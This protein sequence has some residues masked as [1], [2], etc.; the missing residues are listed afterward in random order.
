MFSFT[1]TADEWNVIAERLQRGNLLF[2]TGTTQRMA[3]SLGEWIEWRVS[4]EAA[5]GDATITLELDGDAWDAY[6]LI[7]LAS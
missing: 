4:E 1:K 6:L 5:E 3:P 2:P 7:E